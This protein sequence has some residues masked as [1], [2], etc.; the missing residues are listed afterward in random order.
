MKRTRGRKEIKN[1]N[2]LLYILQYAQIL[3]PAYKW[4]YDTQMDIKVIECESV[5]IIYLAE[6]WRPM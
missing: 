3:R 6:T 2:G 5:E 4:P 1:T